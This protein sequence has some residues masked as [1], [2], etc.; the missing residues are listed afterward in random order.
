MHNVYV[1]TVEISVLFNNFV[2][3]IIFDWLQCDICI[4]DRYE[5]ARV[6]MHVYWL[7]TL[8]NAVKINLKI[9]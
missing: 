1:C 5:S 9:G 4:F 7:H 2:A 3:N 6:H 8:K